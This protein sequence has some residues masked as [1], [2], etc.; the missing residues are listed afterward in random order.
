MDSLVEYVDTFVD[1][2]DTGTI[3]NLYCF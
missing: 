3:F 1:Y 2:M